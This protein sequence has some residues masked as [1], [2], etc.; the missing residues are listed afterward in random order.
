MEVIDLHSQ[1]RIIILGWSSF[2]TL[3]NDLLAFHAAAAQHSTAQHSPSIRGISQNFII[4]RQKLDIVDEVRIPALVN[5]RSPCAAA[6]TNDAQCLI[7]IA[8]SYNEH[9]YRDWL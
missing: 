7:C 8:I 4:A 6:L 3:F 5:P 1:A 9:F 2:I